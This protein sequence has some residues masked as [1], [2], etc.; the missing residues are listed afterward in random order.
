MTQ[1]REEHI[2][3]PEA[4]LDGV[5]VDTL[6]VRAGQH[7]TGELEHSDAI[8][9]T[10]SFVYG[11][12]AQAA[13]RFGGEE[14]GNIYSRFTNPTV[15]AFEE[16]IAAMEG[17]ERA[18]ATASGMAAILATCMSMLQS[19]DHVVCSRGVFGTTNVLFQKYLA[20]F[21]VSTTFVGLT[22]MDGWRDAVT[23]NTRMLFIETPSNPLCEVADMSALAE[24][25]HAHG[26]LF[27][28]DNCFCTPVLQRPL[29]FGAD[30]VIHSATKYLDGQG[31]CVGGVVVGSASL[32]EEVYGFLRSAGPTMSP[33]NAW[34]FHKGLETLP[35]RMRAHCENALQLA[36]WLEQQSAV[37]KVYY[38]GLES[39]PQHQLACRQQSGFGGVLSFTVRGGQAEAWAFIDAT[40]MVSITA[41]LGDVKTTITHP[42]TTTHGRLSPD[43]KA[44]AGITDNLIR[45]SVGIEA[46]EDLKNDMKRGLQ[47][48][49]N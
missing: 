25:A 7:R 41:N 46:L 1:S 43:D 28:V 2:M 34:V 26:A 21:G 40:R 6:A 13:A 45:L 10:S 5:S 4:D 11:S 37:E 24:L 49:Q 44:L 8:F 30:I 42:G 27:V 23:G 38:A 18:V 19:G 12:A 29:E 17:G 14:P 15:K 16:R 31:R 39:H 9:P 22:D 33:F 3:I 35:I 20:R 32:M 47:A 48:L 36:R